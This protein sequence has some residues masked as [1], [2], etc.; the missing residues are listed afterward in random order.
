MVLREY[1]KKAV[2]DVHKWEFTNETEAKEVLNGIWNEVL[3]TKIG[4][5]NGNS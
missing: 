4:E 5:I 2:Q 3:K 1:Q